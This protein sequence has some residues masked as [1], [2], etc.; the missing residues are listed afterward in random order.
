MEKRQLY[1]DAV[2][3]GVSVRVACQEFHPCEQIIA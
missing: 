3:F 1:F 2:L